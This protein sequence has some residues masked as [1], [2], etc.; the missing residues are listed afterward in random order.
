[1]R[2]VVLVLV[3]FVVGCSTQPAD[4]PAGWPKPPAPPYLMH[5][6]GIAGERWIDR[7]MI[8]GLREGGFEG[9][10]E[11]YDW[12]GSDQGLLALTN[13]TRHRREAAEVARRITAIRRENPGREIVITA[14]SGGTGVAVYALQQLPDDVH[15]DRVILLASALSTDYDLSAALRRVDGPVFSFSSPFDVAVLKVGTTLLGTIDGKKAAAAGCLGF[16]VPADADQEQYRKLRQFEYDQRWM[17]WGNL[18]SH[19]GAMSRPFA[20]MVLAPLAT[21]RSVTLP[22]LPADATTV[23]ATQPQEPSPARR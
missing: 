13:N 11:I 1:M 21:G 17:Q 4:R 15:V 22:P 8:R 6:P 18:G 3:L 5:L 20:R 2:G 7:N 23:P 12:T 16:V 14:H 10:T 9:E 19:I